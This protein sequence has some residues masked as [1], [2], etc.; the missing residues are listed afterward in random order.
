MS[1][2]AETQAALLGFRKTREFFVGVDSDGCVFDT[3]EVKHKECFIPQFV[4][5]FRLA[6]V[7]RL[8]R[9]ACEFVNLYSKDRG[10]NRFPAYLKALDLLAGRPEVIG[11][12]FRVP[13]FRGLRD[14]VARETRLGNPALKVAAETTGDPDLALAYAWSEEVNRVIEE[15]VRD[16]PPFPRARESLEAMTGR[17]DVMVVSATPAEALTRE[18]RDAGLA[19]HVALIAGQEMGSKRDH[20]ALAAPAHRY[21]RDKVLMIGDAP[22]DRKAAEGN[23]ALFSPI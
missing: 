19:R 5:H 23:G 8:A 12:G 15:T 20:L 4:K 7:S 16:V 11:R 9:E 13:P 6:A 2:P 3:M 17:A 21:E 14:W 1:G 18:W 22:G 10:A